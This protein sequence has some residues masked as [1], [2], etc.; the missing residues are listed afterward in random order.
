MVRRRRTDYRFV[1]RSLCEPRPCGVPLSA[2]RAW[3]RCSVMDTTVPLVGVE[4]VHVPD[5]AQRPPHVLDDAHLFE[6]RV[7]RIGCR[8]DCIDHGVAGSVC[9]DSCVLARGARRLG[10]HAC[11]L[12]R[13]PRALSG[14]SQP[15]AFL[16]NGF[17]RL[18][19]TITNL[20]RFL[21]E[22][23]ELF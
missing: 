17:E 5:L 11:L 3:T 9:G 8:A 18:A 15:L 13:D 4:L 21:S 16:S 19:M 6:R 10:G 2:I 22:S 14:F 23:P 7:Q 20:T 1:S 12:A